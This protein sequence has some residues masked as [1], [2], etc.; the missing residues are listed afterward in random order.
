MTGMKLSF[1][2]GFQ[3]FDGIFIKGLLLGVKF[4]FVGQSKNNHPS[5]EAIRY[6]HDYRERE[7]ESFYILRHFFQ[8][9]S[10]LS[11]PIN[12]NK[13]HGTH[14]T[15]RWQRGNGNGQASTCG[16]IRNVSSGN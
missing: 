6:N 1:L 2:M 15:H 14:H 13:T 9:P 7:I 5:S 12:H 16:A 4:Y 3:N 8:S 10:L 11:T